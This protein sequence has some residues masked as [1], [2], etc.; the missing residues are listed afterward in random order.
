L[1]DSEIKLTK[2][3]LKMV[4]SRLNKLVSENFGLVKG[5]H[6]AKHTR[7]DPRTGGTFVAGAGGSGSPERVLAERKTVSPVKRETLGPE[8]Q[9]S[10]MNDIRTTSSTSIENPEI[11]EL[12]IRNLHNAKLEDLQQM[13]N[14]L[15]MQPRTKSRGILAELM[16][17]EILLRGMVDKGPVE[18]EMDN[19]NAEK[20]Q[21]EQKQK[22]KT[23]S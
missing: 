16:L 14:D 11:M 23:K 1:A 2:E 6:V 4:S 5:Q 19:I 20:T 10:N 18:E 9:D 3:Q 21:L 15:F 12:V 7:R 8:S 22:E 17:K 13:A